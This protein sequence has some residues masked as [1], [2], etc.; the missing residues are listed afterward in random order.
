M[1]G[2]LTSFE[3]SNFDNYT[4]NT[5][6]SCFKSQLDVCK[7]GKGKNVKSDSDT[8][9]YELDELEALMARR[10]SRG[11]GQYK[12]KLPI[13][14]FSSNKFGH[15]NARCPD[16]EDKDERKERNYKSGRYEGL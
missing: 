1:T 6:E 9:D 8:F 12:R 10:F 13:M 16:G 5:I 4:P 15:I 2:R 14:Y 7:K 11:R 3:M